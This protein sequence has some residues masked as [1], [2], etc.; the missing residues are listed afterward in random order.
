MF[1]PKLEL[2][3]FVLPF[4]A[5]YNPAPELKSTKKLLPDFPF[6]YNWCVV[7][8]IGGHPVFLGLQHVGVNF[9][10]LYISFFTL[11]M[12]PIYKEF[13]FWSMDSVKLM[14][15]SQLQITNN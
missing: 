5:L 9:L 6:Y 7:L 13:N 3:E 14:A 10:F 15:I 4:P 8:H 12:E 2:M 1:V 11:F